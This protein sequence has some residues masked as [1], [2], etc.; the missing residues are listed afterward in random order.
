MVQTVRECLLLYKLNIVAMN[1]VDV[2][3][4]IMVLNIL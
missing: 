3:E 2:A 1:K 4:M